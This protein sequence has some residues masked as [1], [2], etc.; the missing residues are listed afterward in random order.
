MLEERAG[1][2][3]MIVGACR[4]RAPRPRLPVPEGRSAAWCARSPQ[5]VRNQLQSLR[6]GGRRSGH[7]A[8]RG[9]RAR[10]GGQ[11]SDDACA[12]CSSAPAR[13]IE[14]LHLA[15][16]ID[17]DIEVVD[18]PHDETALGS[19]GRG[20]MSTAHG[21][22]RRRAARG[23]RSRS[24]C[25]RRSTDPRIGLVTLTRVDVAPDLSHALVFWSALDLAQRDDRDELE[26][27]ERVSTARRRSCAGGSR[28]ELPLQAH[29]GAALPLRSLARARQRTLCCAIARRGWGQRVTRRA[30]EAIRAAGRPTRRRANMARRG[31]RRS[32]GLRRGFLVVDKPARLDVARRRRCGARLARHAARRPPR[33]A[34]PARHRACCRSR[35]ATRRSSCPSSRIATRRYAGAIA[36]GRDT[37]T[38]DAEGACCDEHTGAL[39]RR[40]ARARGARRA[41]S[42]EIEQVPPMFQRG[43][44]GWRAAAQARARRPRGGA[45]AEAGPHRALRAAASTTRRGSRSRW[46][47]R[48]APTCACS[49]PIS[50][51]RLGC[52]AHLADLRRTRS[53]PFRIDQAA[54]PRRCA[55]RRQSGELGRRLISAL[56]ALGCPRCASRP[57]RSSAS[58]RAPRSPRTARP[59]CRA[60][61]WSR[62][63][64]RAVS[65]RSSSCGP[66][67]GCA[68]ARARAVCGPRLALQE[69]CVRQGF[70]HP[71]CIA[72]PRPIRCGSARGA[73]TRRK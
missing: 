63:T 20:L 54:R 55:W 19:G 59:K 35:C 11:R 40:G 34:R 64:T 12:R 71:A 6:R 30:A 42:G 69:S 16:V 46:S 44:A 67:A 60:P 18:L 7:L 27:T 24:C 39:A 50:G 43:Q 32:V 70:A 21:A 4:R 8:A 13:F 57:T 66:A 9:A 48:A 31:R 22:D 68:A 45:R 53:G 33:H 29:A 36:L 73:P 26:R 14:E 58:L 61:G 38:L 1:D 5:R 37:D 10:G 47:A 25:A 23:A 15:E 51:E 3:R 2:A 65:S 52:G 41:S 49:P 28:S 17:V 72:P 62:T 56:T